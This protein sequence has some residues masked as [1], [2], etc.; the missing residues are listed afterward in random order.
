ML[1]DKVSKYNKF[2][3]KHPMKGVSYDECNNKYKIQLDEKSQT[4]KNL[5][6]A[7][8]KIKQ[9]LDSSHGEKIFDEVTKK[10]IKNK[11]CK[12][13]K[14]IHNKKSYYDIQ[15]ILS[16]MELKN[17]Y[18]KKKYNTVEDKI[19]KY[20]WHKNKFGGYI[21]RELITVNTIKLLIKKS[22]KPAIINLANLLNID[23][24]SYK[25]FDHETVRKNLFKSN[26]NSFFYNRYKYLL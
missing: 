20:Y 12:I 19:K 15:H 23:T 9:N 7:I 1:D 26:T 25:I 14:Y 4:I 10:V 5:H 13:I 8:K 21:L 17:S 22:T 6:D 2:N 11:H 18:V 16:Q 24:L 3:E